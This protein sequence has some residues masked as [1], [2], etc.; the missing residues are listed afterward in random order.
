MRVLSLSTV[1]QLLATA[2]SRLGFESKTAGYLSWRWL[3]KPLHSKRLIVFC[4]YVLPGRLL[5]TWLLTSDESWNAGQVFQKPDP[6]PQTCRSRQ[7][8]VL[9]ASGLFNIWGFPESYAG[10]AS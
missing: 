2:H 8:S 10:Y 5:F 9:A 3:R 1:S 7:T 4:C 6:A